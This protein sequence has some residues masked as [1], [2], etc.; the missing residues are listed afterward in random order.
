MKK[1]IQ[2]S[3]FFLVSCVFVTKAQY[4]VL[5]NNGTAVEITASSFEV[6]RDFNN[7]NIGIGINA[8]KS[9]TNI[10]GN[11]N[12]YA[13]GYLANATQTTG[14]DNIS[15]GIGAR[16]NSQV[17]NANVGV[18]FGALIS[19]SGFSNIGIGALANGLSGEGIRKVAIG[20]LSGYAD[21]TN[22]SIAI[23]SNAKLFSN[24]DLANNSLFI[25]YKSGYQ[26][27]KNNSNLA[28]G[29]RAMSTGGNST[30]NI[31]IGHEALQFTAEFADNNVAVGFQAL[32][33]KT[34]SS[35]TQPKRNI[36]IGKKVMLNDTASFGSIGVG[37]LALLS[38]RNGAGTIAVGHEA[39]K[40]FNA[41]FD[42]I[43]IGY[44]AGG[45]LTFSLGDS[46][47]EYG[48]YDG[49]NNVLVG[50]S[51][52]KGMLSAANSNIA[53]GSQALN[54]GA[55]NMQTNSVLG[56]KAGAGINTGYSNTFIGSDAKT[57]NG[58]IA[59]ATAIGYNVENNTSN[60]VV[61]G[62]SSVLSIGGYAAFTNFSDKRLKEQIEY[63]D[64][65]GL[66]FIR[67]L[68]TAKYLYK[69]DPHKRV[70][71]G[72]IAQE[73]EQLLIDQNLTFSGLIKLDDEKG[74]YQLA[75]EMFAI[76]LI[77]S[78]KELEKSMN[79]LETQL[80]PR[81]QQDVSFFTSIIDNLI[82]K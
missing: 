44:R 35:E 17:G 40:F 73:V 67:N 31:A 72:L 45:L 80:I 64:D 71:Q 11:F 21:S 68:R 70:R 2:L 53:I 47:I 74:T 20:Y 4:N 58:S 56:Y 43:G 79:E 10:A 42:N 3:L 69:N 41:G 6:K 7:S 66:S 24:K 61:F 32:G 77:N 33:V 39:F 59:Q 14:Q 22:F 76:P 50:Y 78:T 54:N 16:G 25:G 28:I 81:G 15:I 23:G 1:S 60:T 19:N 75:Y 51:A 65:L 18:G 30:L 8:Q 49:D 48:F 55:N 46:S 9:L 13:F 5:S 57:T 27:A 62:N 26:L 12:N 34:Y 38:Q 36:A 63:K 37:T 52:G 82:Q 29:S